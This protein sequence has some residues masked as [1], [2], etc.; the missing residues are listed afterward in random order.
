MAIANL[1]ESMLEEPYCI[2]RCPH[3][4]RECSVKLENLN[5]CST[6][7]GSFIEQTTTMV[8]NVDSFEKLMALRR[9]IVISA[10]SYRDTLS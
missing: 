6:C 9:W 4:L 7:G 5:A 2:Y 8:S 10:T 1:A 3:L